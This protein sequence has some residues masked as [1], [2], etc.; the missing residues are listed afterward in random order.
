MK[1][2]LE[3]KSH[4]ISISS[5]HHPITPSPHHPLFFARTSRTGGWTLIELV[6][7]MTVMSVLT[8]AIIPIVR[9]SIRR[10]REQRLRES[11]REMRSA[12]DE[13]H[14]DTVGMLCGPTGQA[15][16]IP[17]GGGNNG[18][19]GVNNGVNNGV[20]GVYLDPRSRVVIADCTIFGVD[21]PERYP[22]S[23]ETL[24]EG[25]DVIPRQTAGAQQ[26][27]SV[28]TANGGATANTGT[29][30]PKKK[31]YLREIPIDPVTGKPDWCILSS[32]DDADGGCS[33][34][35]DNVFDVRSKAEGEAL[36][37]E[38]YVDW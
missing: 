28:S 3:N 33:G 7:T 29:P 10:Q 25:V 13:F 20:Q 5:P 12:I 36:N 35:P 17:N 34:S 14:R 30:V 21:N 27:G 11:L 22:P 19:N 38:K 9:T 2:Q 18:I 4:P 32:Y 15:I 6:I 16:T 23:L 31:R 37:G 8:L 26:F 1:R 24:V